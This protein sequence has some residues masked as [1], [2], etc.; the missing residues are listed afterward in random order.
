VIG[1]VTDSERR[2]WQRRAVRVLAQLLDGPGRELPP[3]RWTVATT[4]R[5]LGHVESHD[6][7]MGRQHF[8]MWAQALSA[9]PRP[10]HD[11]GIYTTLRAERAD[12]DGLV[13][14]GLVADLD[15]PGED[16][17]AEQAR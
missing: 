6:P 15:K 16:L 11:R 14:V 8:E 12:Y 7:G 1:P 9:T 5:L 13:D 3:L 2:G 17:L 10:E 4:A